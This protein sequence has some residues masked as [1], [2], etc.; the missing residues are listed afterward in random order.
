MSL[1]TG[2]S[3]N[4][5]TE[6]QS[7]VDLGT[8]FIPPGQFPVQRFQADLINLSNLGFTKVRIAGQAT[9]G[10]AP[11][12]AIQDTCA[13][14]AKALGF[15]VMY[16]STPD[17]G[18][19]TIRP[20]DWIPQFAIQQTHALKVQQ[21]AS[22]D[23][24]YIAN[25]LENSNANPARV[26]QVVS[27]SRTSNVVTVIMPRPTPIATGEGVVWF[28]T[29]STSGGSP[30]IGI[31]GNSFF[32]V[33]VDSPTQF[34]FSST[35]TDGSSTGGVWIQFST[36]TIVGIIK[37]QATALKAAG[38]TMKLAN[39]CI[40]GGQATPHVYWLSQW[41]SLGRGDI[42]WC[43]LN[44]YGSATQGYPNTPDGELGD[45]IDEINTGLNA[46]GTNHFR[47]LEWSAGNTINNTSSTSPFKQQLYTIYQIKRLNYLQSKPNLIYYMFCLRELGENSRFNALQPAN[48]SIGQVFRD[49]WWPIVGRRPNTT[50]ITFQSPTSIAGVRTT[51]STVRSSNV[52]MNYGQNNQSGTAYY[53]QTQE[54]ID[55]INLN[56]LGVKKLRIPFGSLSYTDGVNA[57]KLAMLQALAAGY[58]VI[59]VCQGQAYG[60]ET[61]TTWTTTSS[62][63]QTI[64]AWANSV[65]LSEL[66]ISNELEASESQGTL[67]DAYGKII[68]LASTIKGLYPSLKISS[69]LTQDQTSK[70][71]NQLFE[72]VY[73][74]YGIGSLDRLGYNSYGDVIGTPA[75]NL[76]FVQTRI[77]LMLP[78]LGSNL[79][80]SECNLPYTW[81][82]TISSSDQETE[83]AAKFAYFDSIN[84]DYYFFCYS[85]TLNNDYY[86]LLQTN[87]QYRS[88]FGAL[89]N[90]IA[91]PQAGTRP[92]SGARPFSP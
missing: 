86:G 72:S 46:F 66:C 91:R 68:A 83:L 40:Q 61:N 60:Q 69:S 48:S 27:V 57:C 25:E 2:L 56:T 50:E 59:G 19:G 18:G 28:T 67:T 82:F 26:E 80:I 74:T 54:K 15:E 3:I 23:I 53:S 8:G 7:G 16:G 4:V 29:A 51:A 90:P 30:V 9:S 32:S 42:D 62:Q 31:G 78:L 14:M 92:A 13:K 87:G 24:Y 21:D 11:I 89:F 84:I 34:H 44:I 35:G 63:I 22:T 10:Y 64:A 1:P 73:G 41:V 20:G 37:R 75:Q 88:W 81:P 12:V 38:V 52:C 58:Y 76:A 49:W 65:G 47:V 36:N 6:F 70:T 77:N 39:A 33:T 43:C 45:F 55:L 17:A 79:Y 5:S 71:Y 85:W